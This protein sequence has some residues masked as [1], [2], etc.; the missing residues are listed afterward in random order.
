M[1]PFEASAKKG[2]LALRLSD[3]KS[4]YQDERYVGCTKDLRQ[5]LDEHNAGRSRHT[6]TF[7]PWR[8]VTYVA[9]A[10]RKK[11][12]AFEL[13]LKSGSGHAFARKRRW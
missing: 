12:E 6:S 4:S 2:Q 8:L 13:Y 9:F 5:R 10:D 7:L 3:R 11:A 1:A